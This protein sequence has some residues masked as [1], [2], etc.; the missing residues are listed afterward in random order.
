LSFDVIGLVLQA[1]LIVK[2]VL[3]LLVLMS[4]VSWAI[5]LFKWREI[6][7]AAQD[8]EAFLEVYHGEGFD[9]AYDAARHLDRSP[10]AV[11]FLTSC[12]EMGRMAKRVGQAALLE[13]DAEQVG[14]VT[15]RLPWTGARESERLGRGLSFLATTGSAAPFIGLFGTVVGIIQSFQGIARSGSASLAVVAPGISEALIATAVGLLAAIPASIFYNLFVGRIEDIHSS[16]DRF[17]VELD[18]DLR[19]LAK[20]PSARLAE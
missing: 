20:N 2:L 15:K 9:V 4:I 1:G 12:S 18:R 3:V 5:I 19:L 11:L 16:I 17:I 14:I 7:R 13:L 6:R 8:S 10:L